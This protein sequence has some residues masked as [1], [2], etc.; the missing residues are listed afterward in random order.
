MLI[1]FSKCLLP[2]FQCPQLFKI[3]LSVLLPHL[4]WNRLSPVVAVERQWLGKSRPSSP[5]TPHP[6]R[7]H[8]LL[9][10]GR[11]SIHSPL[12]FLP[13]D[14]SLS[15]ATSGLSLCLVLIPSFT[16]CCFSVSHCFSGLLIVGPPPNFFSLKLTV[17]V[18]TE[19]RSHYFLCSPSLPHSLHSGDEISSFLWPLRPPLLCLSH[20][21]PLLLLLLISQWYSAVPTEL[22]TGKETR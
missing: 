5:T 21:Q 18:S 17:L 9:S 4:S 12:P 6:P 10:P 13:W 22:W 19:Y 8:Y 2:P 15:A 16:F 11:C 3:S 1:T 20:P 14:V 7:H